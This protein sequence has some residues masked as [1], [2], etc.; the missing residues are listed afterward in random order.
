MRKSLAIKNISNHNDIS[1]TETVASAAVFVCIK[2]SPCFNLV[3]FWFNF[4][5]DP[6][7]DA[8]IMV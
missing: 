6:G 3:E 5:A 7:W 2:A 4:L 8:L 1:V